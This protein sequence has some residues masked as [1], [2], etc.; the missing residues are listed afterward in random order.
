MKI[1]IEIDGNVYESV[2]EWSKSDC[3]GCDLSGSGH[4]LWGEV[5]K[6]HNLIFIQK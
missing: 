1:T 2:P 3:L 6:A 4:C 5:C